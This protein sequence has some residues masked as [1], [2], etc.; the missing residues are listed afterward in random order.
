VSYKTILVH[1]NDERRAH[2]LLEFG[3]EVARA[4]EAHLIGLH[5]F[6][7][8]H[9]TPPVRIPIGTEILGGIKA[10]IREET[11]RIRAIFDEVTANKP[12]VTEWRSITS[13]RRDPASMV[14]DQA[15]AADLVTA[16]QTDPEWDLHATLDFPERLAIESGRPVV[17]VPNRGR[18][19][20]LP[21]RI[22]VCWNGRREAARAVF[23]ALPLLKHTEQAELLT[24]DDGDSREGSLPDT[25]IAAALAHHGVKVNIAKR[26]AS[27]PT[28]GEEIWSRAVDQGAGMLVMGAYGHSRFR[29]FVLGGVTATACGR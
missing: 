23:D 8:Y 18:F 19:G 1:L 2:Q 26:T 14:V 28:V 15:R 9:V 25:E 20:E 22:M 13:D 27:E 16:S 4:F 12:I 17:V 21:K 24:V 7:G 3:V 5:V 11:D 29:E 10:Q 6:P